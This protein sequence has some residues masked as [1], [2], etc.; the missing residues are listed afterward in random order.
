MNK[1]ILIGITTLSIIILAAFRSIEL[2]LLLFGLLSLI[3][4]TSFVLA[5]V[6]RREFQW[7]ITPS[8]YFPSLSK[9]GLRSFIEHG[10]DPE[11]G[12]VRK[13]GTQKEE[14]G[15]EGA[16]S[17]HINESGARLNPG[18][19]SLPRIISFYGDSFVFARQVNDNE[20]FEWHLSEMTHTNVLNFGV[21][22][23]GLDQAFLRLKREYPSNQTKIVVI[24][25]VPSTIVR[26]LCMWK[27]YNEFGNTFGFK[28][29]YILADGK[30]VLK[31]NLIDSPAKFDRYREYL[32]E[33][34][35]YDEFYEKKFK[36]EMIRF[37]YF[38]S[39]ISSPRR[40]I[41]IIALV[42]WRKIFE[43]TAKEAYYPPAMR[44]I[45][46][47][48]L[49]LRRSLFQSDPDAVTILKDIVT[50]LFKEYG[51]EGEFCLYSCGCPKRMTLF[52][53]ETTRE[54]FMATS[55]SR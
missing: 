10:Y 35:K 26:V 31:R 22:N 1:T 36:K 18:H 13:P 20:T 37:P 41:S 32:P 25:V 55:F 28:P 42:L 47:A 30:L 51:R 48:N 43:R 49:Q 19:E 52:I 29:R 17:Y 44:V 23:Y 24:G 16:T 15:K 33:I 11:L 14:I 45:M 38:A 5:R 2:F 54:A 4:L 8:D 39:I 50:S 9:E 53:R 34:N 6:V 27:H 21:G 7:L 46:D 12:W 3:E 40:N